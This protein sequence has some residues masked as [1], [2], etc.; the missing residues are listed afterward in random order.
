[1]I[2]H[3]GVSRPSYHQKLFRNSKTD[4]RQAGQQVVLLEG[5]ESMAK[6]PAE[7]KEKVHSDFRPPLR[8]GPLD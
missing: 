2:H 7:M 6:I 4:Y 8:Y 1:M 5:V 3:F